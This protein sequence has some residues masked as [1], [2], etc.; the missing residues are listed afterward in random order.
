[1]SLSAIAWQGGWPHSQPSSPIAPPDCSLQ[2]LLQYS[3]FGSIRDVDAA[4]VLAGYG[5]VHKHISCAQRSPF[6]VLMQTSYPPTAVTLSS[7]KRDVYCHAELVEARTVQP[8]D[9]RNAAGDRRR[10]ILSLAKDD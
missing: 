2:R 6:V 5:R 3:P 9:E 10:V 7:S 8:S 4:C 1:M